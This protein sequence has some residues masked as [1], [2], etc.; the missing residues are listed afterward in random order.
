MEKGK[1]YCSLL[2]LALTA[3][4]L[5]H[6]S[7]CRPTQLAR[8][9]DFATHTPHHASSLAL[10]LGPYNPQ[11]IK[12]PH[13]NTPPVSTHLC[14]ATLARVLVASHKTVPLGS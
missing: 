8:T 7:A 11:V 9:S 2:F 6:S 1:G 5:H 10:T 14:A 3:G 4:S 13:Q 12:R